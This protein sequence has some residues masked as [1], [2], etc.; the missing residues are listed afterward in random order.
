M[1]RAVAK[2]CAETPSGAHV[3]TAQQARPRGTQGPWGCVQDVC[4]DIV[5]MRLHQGPRQG[6]SLKGYQ[7]YPNL[8]GCT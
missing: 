5:P 8:C 2:A 6:L 1:C 7:D 4:T 3:V